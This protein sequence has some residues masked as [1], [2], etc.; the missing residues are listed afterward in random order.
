M[1]RRRFLLTSLAG[2]LAAPLVA[3]A[4]Q[5]G[6]VYRVGWLASAP[7]PENLQALRAGLRAFGYAEGTNVVIDERYG[8][9]MKVLDAAAAETLQ[10]HPDVIVTDGSV[11]ALAVKRATARVPVVFVSGDPVGQHVVPSLARPGGN[12]TGL[13]L[14]ST[15]LNVKRL[16]LLKEAFPA[17]SRLGVLYEARQKRLMLP[18]IDSGASALGLSL[19]HHEV[20]DIADIEPAFAAA[21][22]KRLDAVMPLSSALLDAEKQRVVGLAAKYRLPAI[23]E[24]RPFPKVG[25]LM[26]YG[27]DIEEVFRRAAVYVDRILKGAKPADLPVEQATKF[28]LVINLKTA[29]SLGLTIPPSL[30]SRADQVIE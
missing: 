6:K 4:Q 7:I 26:S 2:A 23:Y 24:H 11:A 10:R 20:H 18:P 28:E 16:G 22:S 17:V 19:V 13:A 8:G 5:A 15:E 14:I 3:A 12:L 25:G 27:P 9:E 30:L 21:V 29:R 1:D